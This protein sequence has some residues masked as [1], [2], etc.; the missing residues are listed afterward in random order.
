M[1]GCSQLGIH[2]SGM[3]GWVLH[4]KIGITP[5]R[6][7]VCGAVGHADKEPALRYDREIEL[8]WASCGDHIP[9]LRN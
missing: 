9:K 5:E 3:M 6:R 4:D 7:D 2:L 1:V 8:Q